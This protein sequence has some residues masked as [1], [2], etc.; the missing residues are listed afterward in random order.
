MRER[1]F[2]AWLCLLSAA[3][4]AAIMV[5]LA[6]GTTFAG[7]S[8]PIRSARATVSLVSDTDA[9]APGTPLRLALRFRLAAGWHIYW[10]NPGDAGAPPEL[11]PTLP[12]GAQAGPIEWPAPT[13]IAEGPLMA[14]GYTGEVLLPFAVTPPRTGGTLAVRAHATWLVCSD[15]CVPEG[16][17]FVSICR[18]AR[19]RSQPPRHCLPP[20][21]SARRARRPSPPG[22]PRMGGST[23]TQRSFRRPMS[24]RPG[25][26]PIS[27]A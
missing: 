21:A 3:V 23:W 4:F 2:A 9:Y 1:P 27:P 22:S 10:R 25:S 24:R 7:E 11:K 5:L 15:I 14:Y 18:P 6:A 17:I 20:P 16:A 8:A 13:R 26:C 19:R 12:E